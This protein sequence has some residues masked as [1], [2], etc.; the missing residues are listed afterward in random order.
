[1][2]NAVIE[3]M[4]QRESIM[5]EEV[6]AATE[7]QNID[8]SEFSTFTSDENFEDLATEEDLEDHVFLPDD[9]EDDEDN[10]N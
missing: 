1:M 3:G 8:S 2:A 10:G 7:T 5:A 6:A 9:D 4:H